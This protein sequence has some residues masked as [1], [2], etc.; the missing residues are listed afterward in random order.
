MAQEQRYTIL[1]P[2]DAIT[3]I[4][5]WDGVTPWSPAPGFTVRLSTPDD[6]IPEQLSE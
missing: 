5:L 1:D 6:K 2:N 4:I 3:N